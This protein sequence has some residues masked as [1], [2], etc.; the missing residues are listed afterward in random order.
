MSYQIHPHSLPNDFATG[1]DAAQEAARQEARGRVI[2]VLQARADADA[3]GGVSKAGLLHPPAP[4]SQDEGEKARTWRSIDFTPPRRALFLHHLAEQGNVRAAASRVGVSPSSAYLARRRDPIFRAGWDAAVV[5]SREHALQVLANHA[6]D[7][8]REEVWHRGE[9]VGHRVRHDARLLLAHVG[10]L[11][12]QCKDARAQARAERFDELLA[13]VAG[14]DYAWTLRD[15]AGRDGDAGDAILP[16]TRERH[17]DR[18]AGIG[19]GVQEEAPYDGEDLLDADEVA[20][21]D[22][23]EAEWDEWGGR[24]DAVN[25]ALEAGAE[26]VIA[27][28]PLAEEANADAAD[29]AGADEHGEL[30]EEPGE[31][32]SLNGIAPR[33]RRRKGG[34]LASAGGTGG[35]VGM[36]TEF[37]AR[38]PCGPSTCSAGAAPGGA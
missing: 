4:S 34:W 9:L 3:F 2:A 31:V 17:S 25:D 38:T 16:I 22:L 33:L 21:R 27:A 36:G 6:L 29:E 8:V 32:P 24:V 26:P 20:A 23:A 28:V 10:R 7:G 18:A 14:E 35:A 11:D 5:H 15:I 30:G 12:A 1:Q 13:L 37:F 19:F